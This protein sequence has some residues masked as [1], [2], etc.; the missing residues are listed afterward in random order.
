[1]F[2]VFF[3]TFV[4]EPSARHSERRTEEMKRPGLLA[5]AGPSIERLTRN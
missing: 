2:F 5:E 3:V 1:M 4:P